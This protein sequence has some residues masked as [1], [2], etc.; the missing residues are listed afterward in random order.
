MLTLE[1][2]IKF[3]DA[4]DSI[5]QGFDF[6]TLYRLKLPNDPRS[7][8]FMFPD[9]VE[10]I[11]WTKDFVVF[12]DDKTVVLKAPSSSSASSPEDIARYCT[13]AFDAV[14]K[15]ML[16]PPDDK[17]NQAKK[18][19][20]LLVNKE[21]EPYLLAG[22][23][24]PVSL[25]RFSS[26]IFGV[27]SR[28]AHMTI[29]VRSPSSAGGIKIWVPTRSHKSFTYPGLL[30]TSVAG[31]VKADHSPRRCVEEEALEEASLD[32]EA[33]GLGGKIVDAGLITYVSKGKKYNTVTPTLLYC[34]DLEVDEG[35]VLEPNDSEVDKFELMTTEEVVDKML[36]GKFKPNCCLVMMDFFM[37]HGIVMTDEEVNRGVRERM[38]R[39][40]PVPIRPDD[41]W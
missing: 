37:R 9:I 25:Q 35:T 8:G 27:S 28:G 12:Q 30:D 18:L 38:S 2:C 13:S 17:D 1:R 23:S 40:L 20:P 10:R 33:T 6:D 41:G 29:Y 7:H 16:P 22:T 15:G 3:V 24:P 31:G 21:S 36:D 39:K 32:V 34:F 19:F 4:V 5:P 14:V 26:P 11:P